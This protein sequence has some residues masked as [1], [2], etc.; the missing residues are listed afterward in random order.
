VNG[1][2]AGNG[3]VGA[4]GEIWVIEYGEGGSA[5]RFYNFTQQTSM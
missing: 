4:R 2:T 3:G 5:S 1:V